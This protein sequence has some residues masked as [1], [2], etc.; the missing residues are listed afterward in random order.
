MNEIWHT[1]SEWIFYSYQGM[2][3]AWFLFRLLDCRFH[4]RAKWGAALASGLLLAGTGIWG[5]PNEFYL[6]G[7][8]W[9][10]LLVTLGISLLV[11]K[12]SLPKKILISLLPG[13]CAVIASLMSLNLHN[14]L[15]LAGLEHPEMFAFGWIQQWEVPLDFL[16]RGLL[17][18]LLL[19]LI[20]RLTAKHGVQ[21]SRWENILSGVVLGI[22]MLMVALLYLFALT[23]LAVSSSTY[24]ETLLSQCCL[25][26]LTLCIV[27]IN[28]VIYLL[29]AKL[30]AKHKLETENALLKYQY[31]M[32]KKS[33]EEL[34]QH[35]EKLQKI[36]HDIKNNLLVLQELNR[37]GRRREVEDYIQKYLK[38]QTP[39][40]QYAG[41]GNPV[42]NAILNEKCSQ[43]RQ[44]EIDVSLQL[45][46]QVEGIEDV[47]LCNLI[48]NLF[49]NAM[50][51]CRQCQ[52]KKEI[53]FSLRA[54]PGELDLSIRNTVAHSVLA[55]N[56]ALAST[57]PEKENHGLGT[58][59]VREIVSKYR[60][61][62]DYYEEEGYF[63]CHLILSP[64][65]LPAS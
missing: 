33:A 31:D 18:T 63:C 10:Y 20:R 62:L 23:Q 47:D 40:F 4:A 44:L 27:A 6:D 22:S 51:G 48:G 64:Q 15:V 7:A 65:S 3:Y 9:L 24:W 52:G 54:A 12:D 34:K 19:W 58:R 56:P 16:M 32:Q 30:S 42:L 5:R 37:Q 1:V 8:S 41:T 39:G 13:S 14:L 61:L 49:D 59:I 43:A 53:L 25:T 17:Q 29:L 46:P 35:D 50:E 11:M 36:R 26:L 45:P 38:T 55:E 2:L 21:L 57:K 28:V 60:G